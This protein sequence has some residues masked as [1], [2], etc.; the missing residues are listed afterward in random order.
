M[1]QRAAAS[2]MNTALGQSHDGSVF[3]S[4][5]RTST[6]LVSNHSSRASAPPSR[7]TPEA[8][9]PP[10]GMSSAPCTSPALTTTLP[11][12]SLCAT[13]KAREMSLVKQAE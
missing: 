2:L 5:E 1:T 9:Q 3:A 8:F 13:L 12:S 6:H 4:C 11:A 10:K 7:P